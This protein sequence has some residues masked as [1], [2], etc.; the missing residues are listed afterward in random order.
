MWPLGRS[1]GHEEVINELDRWCFGDPDITVHHL[2]KLVLDHQP[3]G[4]T[5]DSFNTLQMRLVHREQICK[6]KIDAQ[7]LMWEL[8]IIRVCS[9]LSRRH[10]LELQL[11]ASGALIQDGAECIIFEFWD[12][13]AMF[14]NLGSD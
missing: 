12:A 9:L 2:A 6:S 7:T 5:I 11:N 3:A 13:G 10:F 8:D 1:T 14:V 4:L